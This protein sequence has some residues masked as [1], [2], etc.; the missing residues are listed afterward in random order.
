VSIGVAIGAVFLG[1][2]LSPTIWMGLG[3]VETGV[4]AMIIPVRK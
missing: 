4:A 1:E 3:Y 2:S